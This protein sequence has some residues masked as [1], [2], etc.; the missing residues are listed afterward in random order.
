RARIMTDGVKIELGFGQLRAIEFR[1]ENCLVLKIRAGKKLAERIDD[2]TSA[3]RDHGVRCIAKC[4]AVSFREVAAAI[5]LITAKHET[6]AFHRDV[7][8]GRRPG[9][10][11]ISRGSAV[12]LNVLRVHVSTEQ[13]HV[14]FPADYRA[15]AAER[16]VEDGERGAVAIAPDQALRRGGHHLAMLAQESSIRGEEQDTAIKNAALT[17]NHANHEI[18]GMRTRRLGQDVDRRA[19]NFNRAFEIA[20]EVF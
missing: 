11:M 16:S 14:I 20:F 6:P 18:D 7:L 12:N 10:A 5:E 8:H 17:L 3:V 19:E 13:G 4:G 2:A 9:R 1:N 15:Q